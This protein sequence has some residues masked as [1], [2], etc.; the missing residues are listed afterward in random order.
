MTERFIPKKYAARDGK[1]WW[2]VWDNYCKC[3]S[4][5]TCHSK[6]VR[7]KDCVYAI[8]KYNKEW[9]LTSKDELNRVNILW[10]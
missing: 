4:R 6:Y 10:R 5:Y 1:V 7:K 2:R 3:W 9:N 8:D